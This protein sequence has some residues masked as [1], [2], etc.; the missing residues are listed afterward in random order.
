MKYFKGLNQEKM[1]LL[2]EYCSAQVLP[3]QVVKGH[4]A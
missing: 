1:L 4:K 2:K 3:S